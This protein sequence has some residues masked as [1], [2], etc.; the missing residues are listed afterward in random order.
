M[1]APKTK[2]EDLQPGGTGWQHLEKGG[3]EHKMPC[4]HALTEMVHAYVPR[5]FGCP[6]S[7]LILSCTLHPWRATV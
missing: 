1:L 7:R 4:H 2:L 6:V 5:S 3:Q